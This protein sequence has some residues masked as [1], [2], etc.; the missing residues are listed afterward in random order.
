[1]AYLLYMGMAS[2]IFGA[3]AV[4]MITEWAGRRGIAALDVAAVGVLLFVIVQAAIVFSYR[5][6]LQTL[7][8]LFTL[9]GTIT[10]IEYAIVA[11]S[12]PR[13]LTGRAATCL[14]LLIFIGAFLVQAGFGQV[15]GL[16]Q[17]D[18]AGHYPAQA[19]R[20]AFGVLVLLQLPGLLAYF[21]NYFLR[22]R[23]VKCGIGLLA[24]KEDYEI[25]SLRSPR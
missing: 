4:G 15:V 6:S 8:V 25:G 12:M 18:L 17:P 1:V 10:G 14:N 9:I 16:W 13:E 23:Q 2:V 11:Q 20:V 24:Q 5:P 7:S 21:C 22:R 19:Y 3:I